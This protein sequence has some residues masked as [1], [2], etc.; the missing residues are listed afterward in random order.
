[1]WIDMNKD[2]SNFLLSCDEVQAAPG[3]EAP[4]VT[5][6]VDDLVFSGDSEP[7]TSEVVCDLSAD[8]LLRVTGEDA[9]SFLQG[10]FSNDVAN[11]TPQS[12]QLNTWST[13]KGRVLALFRLLRLDDGYLIKLPAAQVDTVVKRL[14]MF[15]LRAKVQID[16]ISDHVAI[17]VSGVAAARVLAQAV[18]GDTSGQMPTA[19]DAAIQGNGLLVS[20]VRGALPD[21]DVPR[22]EV[23]GTV[24]EMQALWQALVASGC[25]VCSGARWRLQNIDAGVPAIGEG[26]AEAFVLQMLNLQHIDGVSFKKGCFPGQEVVARMQ[27]L[28]KLKRRMYRGAV[29]GDA[30]VPGAEIFTEGASSAVGK[31]VDAQPDGSGE[32]RLLAVLAIDS[33]EKPLTVG[34]DNGQAVTLHELPYDIPV[35][36]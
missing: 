6:S 20:S 23:V 28:G 9:M 16:V 4:G 12:S 35:G 21:V 24:A 32:S 26:T 18:L 31:V 17:G 34:R 13:P 1:M 27:Y 8:A 25:Q 3:V 14:R 15:V 7:A 22:Y 36:A 5:A 29:S 10:Q 30:P 33:A 11:V 2:W 19:V